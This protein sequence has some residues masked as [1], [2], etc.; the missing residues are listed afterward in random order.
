M[1]GGNVGMSAFFW[2]EGSAGL[3]M[4]IGGQAAEARGTGESSL[5]E[6]KMVDWTA[7]HLVID[8]LLL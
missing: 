5:Q 6:R 8:E 1:L 3:R 7:L 4:R 2:I